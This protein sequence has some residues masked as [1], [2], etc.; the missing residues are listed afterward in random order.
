MIAA[1]LREL[2]AAGL[3]GEA[4]IAAVERIEAAMAP[5]T[6]VRTA[7]QERNARY[8]ERKTSEKRLKA[9]ETSYSD[10]P[11][12]PP[13]ET[14]AVSPAPP[15]VK[16][17]TTTLAPTPPIVPPAPRLDFD[18]F[19]AAWTPKKSKGQAEITFAKLSKAGG[20]PDMATLLDGIARMRT[21]WRWTDGTPPHASTWLNAK[22]WLDEPEP[23]RRAKGW[24]ELEA[25]N[26]AASY[27]GAAMALEIMRQK[28]LANER[29]TEDTRL[30]GPR[31]PLPEVVPDGEGTGAL[32][33]GLSERLT[34][35]WA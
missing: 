8:Y 24:R 13:P 3:E 35:R 16:T 32:V 33:V 5:A 21:D 25:E 17:Q 7:R 15:S 22:G 4:L 19:W 12:F 23:S 1:V 2:I 31:A 18:T 30:D 6:P 34:R 27:S 20:L 28:D 14:K 9:S 11:P 26:N 29:R 10:A